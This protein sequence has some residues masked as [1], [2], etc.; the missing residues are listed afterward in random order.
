MR[1]IFLIDFER[2]NQLKMVAF[3][4][5]NALVRV[6]GEGRGRLE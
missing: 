3:G 1:I 4:N 6:I 5:L 2:L